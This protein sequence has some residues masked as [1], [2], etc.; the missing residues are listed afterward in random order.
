MS[1]PISATMTSAVRRS[2]P[3]IVQSRASSG[4]N[5]ATIWATSPLNRW[6][7][8]SRESRWA[9]SSATSSRWWR[10]TR[11][12]RAS[13]NA[14]SLLR[15]LPRAR[16]ARTSGSVV[17]PTSASSIARPETP[18]TS[19]ATQ[20][21]S[22]PGILQHLVQP[23]GLAGALIDQ[24]LAVAGQLPQLPD[25]AGR[26][27]ARADQTMPDQ[28]GDPG[29][30]G[31]IG[32][33]AGHVLEVLGVQQPALDVVF[34]QVLDRLPA[35][36]RSTPSPPPGPGGWPASPPA[37]PTRRWWSETCGSRCVAHRG[38]RGHAHTP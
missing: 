23:L 7:A 28:L 11:P 12:S 9:N 26:H 27:E 24:C 15:R 29:R 18:S 34:Q 1:T 22:G 33:A 30:V 5:G 17:P 8:S 19:E 3:G 16:S 25:R 6:I 4:E 10:A 31:H 32:L 38:H 20:P 35:A 37:A 36:P 21:S 13:R 2:T 14:G